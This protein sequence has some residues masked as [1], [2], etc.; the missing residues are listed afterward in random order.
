MQEILTDDLLEEL[1][2][3]PDPVKFAAKYKI[4]DRSLPEYLQE[5]LEEKGLRRPDVIREAQIGETY[6]YYI[7]TGQRNPK[8]DFVI[9]LAL[10]MDC[11]LL[12][13]N[14]LLQVAGLNRLYCKNR[15]DVIIIFGIDH[16]YSLQQVDEQLYRFGEDTLQESSE[17]S[18]AASSEGDASG[19][20]AR[21]GLAR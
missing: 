4:T 8:R 17:A 2:R 5:L 7:F 15:R 10:A 16:G 19:V 13:T 18:S 12:E 21:S 3:S 6:G 20:R 11:T 14:R 9:R 1:L